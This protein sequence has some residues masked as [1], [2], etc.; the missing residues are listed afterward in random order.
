MIKILIYSTCKIQFRT[1]TPHYAKFFAYFFSSFA[2]IQFL[3]KLFA[4]SQNV[5]LYFLTNSNMPLETT[6]T[7]GV[8]NRTCSAIEGEQQ[9]SAGKKVTVSG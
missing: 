7:A 6:D 8:T 5:A 2:F 1:K 9:L 4:S 3:K